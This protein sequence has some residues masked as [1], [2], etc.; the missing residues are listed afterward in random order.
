MGEVLAGRDRLIKNLLITMLLF[1]VWGIFTGSLA[2]SREDRQSLAF[3][4]CKGQE[5]CALSPAR[6]A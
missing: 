2:E 5:Q 6:S 3:L 4:L 1:G